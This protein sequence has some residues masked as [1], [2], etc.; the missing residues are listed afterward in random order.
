MGSVSKLTLRAYL[1][2]FLE[3]IFSI[4]NV[5]EKKIKCLEKSGKHFKI[6]KNHL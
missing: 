4:K 3:S 1:A 5:F 6:L 2:V